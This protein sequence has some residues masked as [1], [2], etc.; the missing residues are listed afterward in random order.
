MAGVRFR[1]RQASVRSLGPRPGSTGG[2]QPPG[3][4][5]VRWL[6]T[7]LP[8]PADI[9]PLD[10]AP[11]LGNGTYV[12]PLHSVAVVFARLLHTQSIGG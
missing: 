8:S 2:L 1:P 11:E 9:V 12:L 6:D 10:E 7:S 5:W 3:R 4:R